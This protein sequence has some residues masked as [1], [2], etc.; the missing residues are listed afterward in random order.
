MDNIVKPIV[1]LEIADML[2]IKQA[3]DVITKLNDDEVVKPVDFLPSIIDVVK[4][5]FNDE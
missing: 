3:V 1:E 4:T 2:P 5:I